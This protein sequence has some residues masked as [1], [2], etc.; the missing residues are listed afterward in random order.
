MFNI[1]KHW[2]TIYHLLYPVFTSQDKVYLSIKINQKEKISNYSVGKIFQILSELEVLARSTDTIAGPEQINF[3]D[4]LE[5][6]IEKDSFLLETTAEFMSPGSIWASMGLEGNKRV[7]L[8]SM[9]LGYGALFGVEIG[10]LKIDGVIHKEMREKILYHHLSRLEANKVGMIKKKLDL[11]MPN[12]NAQALSND[13]K[14]D[15]ADPRAQMLLE[16]NLEK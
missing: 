12:Y 14:G 13:E 3:D 6:F 10:T 7:V 2:A 5:S 16:D 1:D 15:P 9:I 4:L 8:L 11:T